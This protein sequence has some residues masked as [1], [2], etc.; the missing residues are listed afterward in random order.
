MEEEEEEETGVHE[1]VQT[2][3]VK[4]PEKKFREI[5]PFYSGKKW[6]EEEFGIRKFFGGR[7][8]VSFQGRLE[9]GKTQLGGVDRGSEIGQAAAA[10]RWATACPAPGTAAGATAPPA[11][12]TTTTITTTM[13]TAEEGASAASGPAET[14]RAWGWET[15]PSRG[16][17]LLEVLPPEQQLGPA[18]MGPMLLVDSCCTTTASTAPSPTPPWRPPP[19]QTPK[20]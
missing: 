10:A 5:S 13:D 17:L 6:V 14:G 7:G 8:S 19:A 3:E 11:T 16:W 15:D 2:D 18:R 20:G 1:E 9:E 12:T 4:G